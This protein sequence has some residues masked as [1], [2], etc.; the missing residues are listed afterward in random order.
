[1]MEDVKPVSIKGIGYDKKWGQEHVVGMEEVK[2][3][4][5]RVLFCLE[6]HMLEQQPSNLVPNPS[7]NTNGFEAYTQIFMSLM[8]YTSVACSGLDNLRFLSFSL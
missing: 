4:N 5:A 1:M 6:V 3:G 8:Q 2:G 7:T